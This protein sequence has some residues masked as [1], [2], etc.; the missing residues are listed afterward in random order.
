V[1]DAA[2]GQR[3]TRAIASAELERF[4]R[5]HWGVRPATAAPDLGGSANLNL[6]VTDD[7]SLQVARVYRPVVTGQRV[8]V[9]QAVRRHLASHGVPCAEPIPTLGGRGWETFHG[10]AVEVEP[11]VA[12][13]AAMH[14]LARVRTGLA[15]LGRIHALLQALPAGPA[16]AAPRFANYVAATGLVQAVA[17]G[18]RR[19]R[20]WQPTPAEARLA[21]LADRLAETLAGWDLDC[22]V[23][24]RRQLVHGDFWDDNVR[25]R[26]RQVALV[27]DFDF[28]GERPRTD[29]LALTLY[30]TSVDIAD[31]TSD[32]AQLAELVGAYEAGLGTRLSQDER[33]AIPCAM[34]RQPLWSIA[35]WVALLD[36]QDTARRHLAATGAELNWALQL[37][38]RI[39]QAQDALTSRLSVKGSPPAGS[40]IN[41]SPQQD[42]TPDQ[43]RYSMI[44]M[45][46]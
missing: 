13:P 33:A 15:V 37:T 42:R 45:I 22:P 23:P 17:A 6:L 35:V 44:N 3:G 32:P 12:A 5:A 21:D 9:L 26:R 16:A 14:T 10:R 43:L 31:I 11:Y 46:V 19:I 2:A 38:G 27:T 24:L 8:A 4:L 7:R 36:N 39:A 41:A 20:A 34:A 18:T 1:D 30:Y 28:L 25:F 40:H 29:D